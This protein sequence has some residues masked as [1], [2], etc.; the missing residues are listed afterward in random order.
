MSYR[1]ILLPALCAALLAAGCGN[2]SAG[3]PSPSATAPAPSPVDPSVPAQPAPS[4]SSV[5]LSGVISPGVEA[6]CIIL[7]SDGKQYLLLFR[8]PALK[9]QAKPDATVTV[10]GVADPTRM[11]T[12][13]QGTPFIV[14]SIKPGGPGS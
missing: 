3:A 9:S 1:R 8:D 5:V 11:T 12:C 14:S 2:P 13:Q 7:Q 10:E 4:S 6:G